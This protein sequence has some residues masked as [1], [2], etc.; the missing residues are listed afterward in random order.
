MNGNSLRIAVVG[1]ND[2]TSAERALG[3]AVGAGI[4]RAGATLVCGGLGGMMEAAAEGAKSESGL[5]IGILPGS[6]ASD[7]NPHI[8]VALP[9]GLGTYRNILVV[10]GANAVIAIKGSYGTLTEIAFALRLG[11]PV[12]GLQTWTLSRGGQVDPGIRV[13]GT[14]DEAVALAVKLAGD[15]RSGVRG[16]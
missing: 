2:C 10:R 7:A 8:D 11:V 1:P 9:T 3:F 4:A 16:R 14:P 12:I 5:T 13:A 15:A 6:D